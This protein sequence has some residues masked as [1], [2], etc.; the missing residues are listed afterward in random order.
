VRRGRTVVGIDDDLLGSGAC[1][2]AD[3]V[4]HLCRRR[5]GLGLVGDLP[6]LCV[7]FVVEERACATCDMRCALRER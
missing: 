1:A 2:G 5:L 3:L 4:D 7:D 6:L